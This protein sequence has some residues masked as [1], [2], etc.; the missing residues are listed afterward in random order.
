MHFKL[1]SHLSPTVCVDLNMY[2]KPVHEN[3]IVFPHLLSQ[4]REQLRERADLHHSGPRLNTTGD[5]IS[6][7]DLQLHWQ[8]YG[9]VITALTTQKQWSWLE[10]ESMG[11]CLGERNLNWLLRFLVCSS[12]RETHSL[13]CFSQTTA[14]FGGNREKRDACET[15]KEP[16]VS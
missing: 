14:Y 9:R 13:Y 2:L 12:W 8:F 3:N 16:F 15:I 5:D 7:C 4:H 6:S 1:Q 10:H 11:K